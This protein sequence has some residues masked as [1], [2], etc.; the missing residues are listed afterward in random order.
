MCSHSD[1][2]NSVRVRVFVCVGWADS[3]HKLTEAGASRGV[4]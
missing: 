2:E 3:Q 1:R 4:T